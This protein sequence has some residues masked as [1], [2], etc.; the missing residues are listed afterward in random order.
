MA[1]E[2]RPLTAHARLG[3]AA[4]PL[5]LLTPVGLDA[6]SWQWCGLP[7]D[8]H[9]HLWPGHGDRPLADTPPDIAALADEVAASYDGAL[10][11]VGVSLGGMV[12]QHVAIRHPERVRSMF[13]ACTTP[14]GDPE[15]MAQ[16]AKIAREDMPAAIEEAMP[17]W[18]TPAFL[19][20]RDPAIAYSRRTLQALNPEAFAQVWEAIAMHDALDELPKVRARTTVL[21]GRQD[22][23]S[24]PEQGE[25]IASRIR[26]ARLVVL[27]G[28]HMLHL[29]DGAAFGAEV[30]DHLARLGQPAR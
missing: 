30:R 11:L 15:T 9:R 1:S 17:R 13:A 23:S 4:M 22:V 6:D 14:K 24:P 29:E 8:A 18:F 26:N 10:D 25:A 19:E 28:P 16:R 7:D 27:D 2:R 5:V 12:A 21:A 20:T 3:C